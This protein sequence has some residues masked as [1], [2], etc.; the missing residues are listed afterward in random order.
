MSVHAQSFLTVTPK[1]VA[2]QAPLS[3]EFSGQEYWS[4]LPFPPPGDLPDPQIKST[5]LM[6]PALAGKFFTSEPP[7]KPKSATLQF[8]IHKL[9]WGKKKEL[10]ISRIYVGICGQHGRERVCPWWKGS[11]SPLGTAQF[12]Q[13][14]GLRA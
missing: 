14:S 2:Q 1:T 9:F 6:S 3:V 12:H 4:G 8:K 10:L 5:S 11:P 13:S 7:G